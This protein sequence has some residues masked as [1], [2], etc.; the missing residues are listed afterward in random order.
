MSVDVHGVNKI[1]RIQPRALVLC[2]IVNWQKLSLSGTVRQT[3][4]EDRQSAVE[5]PLKSMG[6]RLHH[7]CR[8]QVTWHR[9]CHDRTEYATTELRAGSSS[10]RSIISQCNRREDS[11]IPKVSTH[12]Y[13]DRQRPCC[14][15]GSRSPE[16]PTPFAVECSC[17]PF[18][19]YAPSADPSRLSHLPPR[20]AH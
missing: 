14:C 4:R 17:L 11:V 1:R 18:Q 12:T 7:I 10:H 15:S 9:G 2:L 13:R 6:L 19:T 8:D 5:V 3:A 16:G 20:S